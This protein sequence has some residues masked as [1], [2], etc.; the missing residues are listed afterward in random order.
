MRVKIIKTGEIDFPNKLLDVRPVVKNLWY[1]GEMR[2]ELFDK[3][4]AIVGSRRMSRYGKSVVEEVV[5]RFC[6]S[7]Y[8]IISGLMY[9]VD[10]LAHRNT[11][12][13]GGGAIAI[14]G[15]GIERANEVEADRMA[16][17]IV[18]SGGL[19]MSEYPGDTRG[20]LWTFPAR[21]RIVVGLADLVVIVEAG[22]K[23]GTMSTAR[24]A[25]KMNKPIYAVP[26]SMFASS[27]AGANYLIEQGIAKP[28]TEQVLVELL[29]NKSSS[30]NASDTINIKMSALEKEIYDKLELIGPMSVNELSR[31]TKRN[32]GELLT[33]LMQLDLK[34]ILS[35][36]RGVWQIK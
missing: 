23:S 20:Q 32:V 16:D 6:K 29:G 25:Q 33:T 31:V 4:V 5:P 14:L 10:Q 22:I 17:Q 19:V 27:S 8:T 18:A 11:L 24:W 2:R 15:Y 12:L 1:R 3:T 21:N 36:E 35:E 7:G 9:G 13:C 30:V 34:N 26:G 28:L